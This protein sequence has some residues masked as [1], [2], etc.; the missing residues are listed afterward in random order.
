M[1]ILTWQ[2]QAAVVEVNGWQLHVVSFFKF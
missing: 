1:D 2:K